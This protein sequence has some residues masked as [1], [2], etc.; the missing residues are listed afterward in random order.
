MR[1]KC[2]INVKYYSSYCLRW[3][4]YCDK[5]IYRHFGE[6][7]CLHPQE[8]NSRKFGICQNTH[9]VTFKTNTVTLPFNVLTNSNHNFFVLHKQLPLL[10]HKQANREANHSTSYT[11]SARKPDVPKSGT[12]SGHV[13]FPC[14]PLVPKVRN[15]FHSLIHFIGVVL[16]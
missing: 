6:K 4:T 8:R 11:G 15:D 5:Y 10:G 12:S 1:C 16:N 3:E 2:K 7:F 14:R 9:T 13:R